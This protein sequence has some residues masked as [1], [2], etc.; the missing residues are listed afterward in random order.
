MYLV[1]CLRFALAIVV[2]D[3]IGGDEANEGQDGEELHV[4]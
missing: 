1:Y 4:D 3:G 2:W